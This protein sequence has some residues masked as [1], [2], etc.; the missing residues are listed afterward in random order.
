MASPFLLAYSNKK[1]LIMIP[2]GPKIEEVIMANSRPLWPAKDSKK[3]TPKKALELNTTD[4]DKRI[5][6]SFFNIFIA[7]SKSN[8]ANKIKIGN[9]D[10]QI[11]CKF[12]LARSK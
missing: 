2:R 1:M 7:L 8:K 12:R 5:N 10:P 9:T 4:K 11:I 3:G 6:I